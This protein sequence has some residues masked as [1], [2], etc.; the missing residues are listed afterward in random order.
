MEDDDD[1]DDAKAAQRRR[2]RSRFGRREIRVALAK[3]Y[4]ECK[5]EKDLETVVASVVLS[6][7]NE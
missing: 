1:D 2:G 5:M 7:K 6:T 3:A 4:L